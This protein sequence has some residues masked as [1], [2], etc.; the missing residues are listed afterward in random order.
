[1]LPIYDRRP[2]RYDYV[3]RSGDVRSTLDDRLMA[4]ASDVREAAIEVQENLLQKVRELHESGRPATREELLNAMLHLF[5]SAGVDE[6]EVGDLSLDKMP[7]PQLFRYG[8][9]RRGAC[10]YL[11]LQD[12]IHCSHPQPREL[13]QRKKKVSSFFVLGLYRVTIPAVTRKE[14]W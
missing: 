2:G 9:R 11:H 8:V 7:T 4:K 12:Q 13:R 5:L 1:M 6:D 14:L 10:P 3:F